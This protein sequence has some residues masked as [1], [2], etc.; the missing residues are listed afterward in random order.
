MSKNEK[1]AVSAKTA[2]VALKNDAEPGTA[3]AVAS[4]SAFA[5]P[6]GMKVKRMLTVPSLVLKDVGQ[7]ATLRFDSPIRESKVVDTKTKRDPARIA[8]VTNMETGEQN[9]L[10][11]NSVV[12]SNLQRDYPNDGYAGL[13]FFIQN[14]GK[15]TESQRYN[16]FGIAEVEVQIQQLDAA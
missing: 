5:L 2:A 12:E 6:Q 3:L 13:T 11:V 9:I 7:S 16:D 4:K 1:V 10:I 15:R 8:D 14:L